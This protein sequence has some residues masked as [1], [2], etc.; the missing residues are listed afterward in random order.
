MRAHR[1][2]FVL[3]V[4]GSLT[5]CNGQSGE[6]NDFGGVGAVDVPVRRGT[7]VLLSCAVDAAQRAALQSSPVK[8]LVRDVIFLCFQIDARGDAQ[9]ASAAARKAFADQTASLSGLGYAVKVGVGLAGATRP[10]G[11]PKAASPLASASFRAKVARSLQDV[12]TIGDGVELDL[13]DLPYAVRDDVTE[14]VIGFA[15]SPR[16]IKTLGVLVPPSAPNAAGLALG[17]A[18]DVAAIAGHVDRV[19]VMTLDYSLGA[20][21]GPT[22]DSGW[23]VDSARLALAETGSTPVDLAMPLYGWQFNGSSE[24]TI[25]FPSARSLESDAGAPL[26]RAPSGAPWFSYS[27]PHGSGGEVWFDDATSTVLTLAAWPTTVLPAGVG[28]VFY[29]LGAEDPGVW[30]ALAEAPP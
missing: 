2:A 30:N 19:R 13:R 9:P 7:V 6:V 28:V 8:K 1:G 3:L 15:T 23:A 18:V 14:L 25:T 5:A 4:A 29:D 16:P 17:N 21:P 26:E 10:S 24:A 20:S 22:I 27:E 11:K 12:A